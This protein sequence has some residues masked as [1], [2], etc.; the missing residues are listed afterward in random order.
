M[1][2]EDLLKLTVEITKSA[3][4]NSSHTAF[5]C[6]DDVAAFIQT[7]YDKL[8]EINDSDDSSESNVVQF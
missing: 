2:N 6:A 4:S 8:K 1:Y 5:K 3:V 7:V